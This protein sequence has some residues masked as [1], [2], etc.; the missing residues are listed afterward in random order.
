MP[1]FVAFGVNPEVALRYT[2]YPQTPLAVDAGQVRIA[3]VPLATA[4]RL[5][6]CAGRVVALGAVTIAE[7]LSLPPAPEQVIVYVDVP[8]EAGICVDSPESGCVPD[9]APDAVHEVAFFEDHSSTM[10]ALVELVIKEAVPPIVTVGGTTATPFVSCDEVLEVV[11]VL[12][13]GSVNDT[14]LLVP[15]A[16]STE[17]SSTASIARAGET[18]EKKETH[19]IKMNR[20]TPTIENENG[21]DFFMPYIIGRSP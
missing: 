20:N 21:W 4:V 3:E 1:L 12:T 10:E 19:P 15:L 5:N 2:L 18:T 17:M 14:T 6:P 8:V 13:A 16:F 11:A 7:A 9:H